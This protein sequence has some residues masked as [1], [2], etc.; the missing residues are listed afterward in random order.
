MA[1]RHGLRRAEPVRLRK[2]G[3]DED[4]GEMVALAQMVKGKKREQ[5]IRRLFP[6]RMKILDGL[7]LT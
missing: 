6:A 5:E 1:R 4:F 2:N 7:K 3:P